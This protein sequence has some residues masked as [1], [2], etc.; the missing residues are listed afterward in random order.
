[1]RKHPSQNLVASNNKRLALITNHETVG[2]LGGSTPMGKPSLR[3]G[4]LDY[5][6]SVDGLG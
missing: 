1:M 2:W 6:Q 5:V 4:G 3:S